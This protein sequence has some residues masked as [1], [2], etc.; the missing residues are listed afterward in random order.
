M[1]AA[2][3]WQFPPLR[4]TMGTNQSTAC[5]AVDNYIFGFYDNSPPPRRRRRRLAVKPNKQ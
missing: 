1:I 5:L 4:C 2:T 3:G